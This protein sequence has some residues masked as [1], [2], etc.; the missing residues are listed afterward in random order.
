MIALV[1]ALADGQRFSSYFIFYGTLF[2]ATIYVARAPRAAFARERLDTRP[3]G[4]RA[5]SGAGRIGQ[6]HR[7]GRAGARPPGRGRGVDII[8][9][10]SLTPRPRNGLRSL[11]GCRPAERCSSSTRIQELIIADPDFPQTRPWTLSTMC[12]QR[13]V[14]VHVA[15]STMEL[16]IDRA[17]FVPGHTVP[18]F[19]LRPPVFEGLDFAIKRMFDLVVSI[20]GL[21]LF[22]SPAVP[23]DRARDQALL[24]RSRDLSL[25]APRY[26]RQA[27][28]TASSSGRCASTP[29]RSRTTSS[30]STNRRA[31]CS[32]S[33]TIPV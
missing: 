18:L 30:R 11:G 33:A 10:I 17:E 6:A 4:L 2:F 32:R 5:S 27:V 20:V 23:G 1:F 3:G 13:G 9:Y 8:G 7:R 19:K 29:S 14:T 15:P 26:R 12:H 25:R 21:M 22:S 28:L 31:R 16:L 24:A